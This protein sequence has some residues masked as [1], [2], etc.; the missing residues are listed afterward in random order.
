MCFSNG[1]EADLGTREL[2]KEGQKI[3]LPEKS[4]E[5]LA[6]L[7]ARPGQIVR[8]EEFHQK[9]WPNG[10][11]VDFGHNLNVTVSRLRRAL[12]DSA[13]NPRYIE[14]VGSRGYRFVAPVNSGT[15]RHE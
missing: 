8:R 6:L 13:A 12:E 10:T 9:L 5:F 4:F 11:Y 1:F 14:T 7:L 2:R 3:P 15:E